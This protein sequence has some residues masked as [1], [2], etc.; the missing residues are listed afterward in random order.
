MCDNTRLKNPP[1]PKKIIIWEK[2]NILYQLLVVVIL[3]IYLATQSVFYQPHATF[4]TH[5]ILIN[6]AA[7]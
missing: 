7:I 4:L 1:P 6:S 5:V 2:R 3:Y